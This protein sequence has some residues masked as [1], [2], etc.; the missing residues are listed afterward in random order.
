MIQTFDAGY[1]VWVH[2]EDT[3]G[4]FLLCLAFEQVHHVC[5]GVV[6]S[7]IVPVVFTYPH[8]PILWAVSMVG[9]EGERQDMFACKI[10]RENLV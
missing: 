10:R 8:T 7:S 6:V 3:L 1:N 4:A 2:F 9:K 5:V